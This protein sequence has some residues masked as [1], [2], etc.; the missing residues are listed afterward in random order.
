MW[1]R[2]HLRDQKS[3]K[4]CINKPHFIAL[5]GAS[6]PEFGITSSAFL[7]YIS[8]DGSGSIDSTTDM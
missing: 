3:A 7:L 5:E 6:A 8:G 2:G 1:F 4:F